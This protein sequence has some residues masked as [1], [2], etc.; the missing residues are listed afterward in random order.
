MSEQAV[1]PDGISI[2]RWENGERIGFTD[3]S[4][5]FVDLCGAPYYVAHRAHLHSALYQRAIDLGVTV[6]LDSKVS[7]YDPEI[8]CATLASGQSYTADLIVA[9]DVPMIGV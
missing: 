8:P 2:R 6:H 5:S 4:E 1:R 9:A 7:K 3:L